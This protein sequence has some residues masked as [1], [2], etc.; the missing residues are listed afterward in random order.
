MCEWLWIREAKILYDM[1]NMVGCVQVW[2]VD[3][4]DGH[5]CAIDG[6]G[7]HRRRS[8]ING[9]QLHTLK[10]MY[11]VQHGICDHRNVIRN[12]VVKWNHVLAKDR[13]HSGPQHA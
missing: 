11:K 7:G 5:D 13:I 9:S 4:M 12:G 8:H 6:L 3:S 2:V 10:M 1:E